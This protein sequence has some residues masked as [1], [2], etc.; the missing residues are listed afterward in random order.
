VVSTSKV[1]RVRKR[2]RSRPRPITAAELRLTERDRAVDVAVFMCRQLTRTQLQAWLFPEVAD[3]VALRRLGLLRE[4]RHL[5]ARRTQVS[6]SAGPAPYAYSL[7]PE[8]VG[9]VAQE[10]GLSVDEVRKRQRLDAR[11]SWMFYEH[12][13]AVTDAR[14]AFITAARAHGYGLSWRTDEELAAERLQVEVDGSR[15]PVRPDA[16]LTLTMPEGVRAAFFMEVQRASGPEKFVH[17][18]RAYMA[19]W[20]SGAYTADTGLRSLRVLTITETEETARHHRRVGEA[21]GGTTLFWFCERSRLCVEGP[22]ST[23][24]LVGGEGEGRK[25]LMRRTDGG[26][27]THQAVVVRRTAEIESETS[28]LEA[29]LADQGRNQTPDQRPAR[30]RRIAAAP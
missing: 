19:Y 12:R 1:R 3:S 23:I 14:I 7:G 8:G 26:G 25:S 5:L 2:R 10:L 15:L 16:F 11:L 24:W 30:V 22:L 27:T 9:V 4:K 17:K 13:E 20:G 29:G 21:L 18:A 6:T 28:G